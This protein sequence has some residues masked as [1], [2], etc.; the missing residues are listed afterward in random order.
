MRA[1][2][3][4]TIKQS[5]I[6]GIVVVAPLV[7]TI[8][9]VQ[10]IFGWLRGFLNPIIESTGLVALTANIEIA[11]EIVAFII[12]LLLVAVLGYLAQKSVGAWVVALFDRAVGLIPM[13]SVIYGSVRQVSDA[14]LQQQSRYENVVAV[15]YPR[16]GVYA[17]GFVT[18][19]SPDPIETATG[20]ELY[21]VYLP[22]S[23]NPTQ[24]RFALVPTDQVTDVDMSVSRSIRLLV[25]TGIAD[26][27][28]ELAAF[29]EEVGRRVDDQDVGLG[30]AF[31][32]QR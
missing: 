6:A 14:L 2:V 5:L 11:A 1:R 10:I 22:H 30:D 8:V 9:A 18:S 31:D 24:G 23:P 15:E 3:T 28:E 4:E 27:R 20:E 16:E 13:V 12:L 21:N 7:V 29:H 17:L 26:D 32:R 19:E 25:T